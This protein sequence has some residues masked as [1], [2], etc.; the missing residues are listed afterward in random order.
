MLGMLISTGGEA[1]SAIVV[2]VDAGTTFTCGVDREV[3]FD[4]GSVRPAAAAAGRGGRVL[5]VV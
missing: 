1:P 2:E 5:A 3:G 4:V